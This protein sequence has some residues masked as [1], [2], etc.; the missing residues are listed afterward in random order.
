M[1]AA[2]AAD[3]PRLADAWGSQRH[4]LELKGSLWRASMPKPVPHLRAASLWFACWPSSVPRCF[5]Q[6]F[7]PALPYERAE[8]LEP[9]GQLQRGALAGG[10]DLRGH[11]HRYGFGWIQMYC[12]REWQTLAGWPV[13]AYRGRGGVRWIFYLAPWRGTTPRSGVYGRETPRSAMCNGF[14]R[15]GGPALRGSRYLEGTWRGWISEGNDPA[16]P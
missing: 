3:W 1:N 9:G 5:R 6:C 10:R 15:G 11:L 14:R 13:L 2:R 12:D 8:A 16:L 4:D 7:V